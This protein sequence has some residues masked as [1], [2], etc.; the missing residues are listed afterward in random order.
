MSSLK[1]D[2]HFLFKITSRNLELMKTRKELAANT[3]HYL[4]KLKDAVNV[5]ML[6]INMFRNTEQK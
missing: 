6:H 5:F 2:A 4:C 3:S 1:L